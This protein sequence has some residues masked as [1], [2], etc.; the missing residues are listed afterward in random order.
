MATSM[1]VTS[2]ESST[3]SGPSHL[4]V[5]IALQI[6]PTIPKPL[7]QL[8][9]QVSH[10]TR[11]RRRSRHQHVQ[12]RSTFPYLPRH[13]QVSTSVHCQHPSAR[14]KTSTKKPYPAARSTYYPDPL[15]PRFHMKAPAPPPSTHASRSST[16]ARKRPSPQLL[17]TR[18]DFPRPSCQ[19]NKHHRPVPP[20]TYRH[21]RPGR[22]A[23]RYA[24]TTIV[25]PLTRSRKLPGISG[26]T[27]NSPPTLPSPRPRHTG[28][29]ATSRQPIAS[30]GREPGHPARASSVGY[31]GPAIRRSWDLAI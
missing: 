20:S 23:A 29:T 9:L 7:R 22:R 24:S 8:L 10:P 25:F 30:D 21:H 2:Q 18:P 19:I 11:Y 3:V 16:T 17:S 6:G 5:L 26:V 12:S 27:G 14:L 28:E 31:L 15:F 4:L 1:P 13:Q